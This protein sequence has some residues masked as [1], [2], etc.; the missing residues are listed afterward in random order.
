GL[1]PEFIGRLPVI[2]TVEHLDKD[3]LVRVLTEPKNA[4]LKQYQKM[5][6]MD[7]VALSFDQS[8]LDAIAEL[9]IA[10]ETGARG[11]RSILEET[12]GGVMFDL[13]SRDD[14]A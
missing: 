12:L 8:A 14:V 6:Q 9:A 2:T 5:F 1:I 4:L 3:A 13:P 7:G 11:L 10:R